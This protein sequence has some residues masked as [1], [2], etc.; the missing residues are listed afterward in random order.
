MTDSTGSLPPAGWY[1]D[2]YGAPFERW[3]DGA[4]WTEH[5]NTPAPAAPAEPV[6]P[7]APEP[8]AYEP[9][10]YEPVAYEPVAYEPVA[11]TPPALE[12]PPAATADPFAGFVSPAEPA[13]SAWPAHP[14]ASEQPVFEQPVFEQPAAYEP[15]AVAQPAYESP[16]AYE[17][18]AFDQP[19]AYEP[20]KPVFGSDLFGQPQ[21][22]A[23]APVSFGQPEPVSQADLFSRPAA[24]ASPAVASNAFDFGFNDIIAG[25]SQPATAS[26]SEGDEGLFGSWEPNEYVEPPRNGLANTGLALGVVSFFL[27][28]VAGIPGLITSALGL[29]RSSKF[30][31]E[32]DGPVGRGKAIAGIALSIVGSAVSAAVILYAVQF[33]T[34]SDDT[35]TDANGD[36]PAGVDA[37]DLTQNGGLG[38]E[39]GDTGTITLAGSDAAAVQFTVTAITPNFTC[40]SAES[41]SPANGQ[42]IA[43]A[44]NFTM[45]ADYLD[46]MEGGVP[47]RMNE[48]DWIGFLA[49]DS[50]TQVVNTDAGT[51]C[52]PESEQFPAEFP[53]GANASGTIVLDMATDVY[54]ISWG[55]S[56]VTDLDPGITRWEWTVG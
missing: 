21:S 12:E 42:F 5:T 31:R 3:W 46:R 20:E 32:G 35:T 36:T 45:S 16:A 28:A 24:A 7:V 9:A 33:F 51:S 22:A 54:A 41:V 37:A 2:P 8:V 26:T 44:M 40:T 11:Y 17:P 50:G 6:A 19:S 39:I 48:S 53:A 30:Q 10:A 4:G 25:G 18:P 49:D 34:G 43:V 14:A 23:E 27:S 56:G 1:P 55:P 29:V 52:I 15:P 13:P 47:L 38:L